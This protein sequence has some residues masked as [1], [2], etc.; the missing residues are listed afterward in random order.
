MEN[1]IFIQITKQFDIQDIE[2]HL[3]FHFLNS[4]SISYER[5]KFIVD[6]LKGFQPIPALLSSIIQLKHYT[7]EE[8]AVD[9]E[10]LIPLDDRKEW[11]IFVR[12]R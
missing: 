2:K 11:S 4:N 10:L 5:C 1:I 7:I 12:H 6:Y 8:I 9:M 3:V